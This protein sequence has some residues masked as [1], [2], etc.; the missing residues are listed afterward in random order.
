MRLLTLLNKKHII[1]YELMNKRNTRLLFKSINFSSSTT[2]LQLQKQTITLKSSVSN[3]TSIKYIAVLKGKV[4]II[5][6][7]TVHSG[8]EITCRARNKTN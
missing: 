6:F 2:K 7:A 5:M 8:T 1:K 3:T 4:F